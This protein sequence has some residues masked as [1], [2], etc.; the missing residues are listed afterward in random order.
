M[1]QA[2]RSHSTVARLPTS[3]ER[4]VRNPD[5]WWTRP[6]PQNCEALNARHWKP[7]I[8]PQTAAQ[9]AT[10]EPSNAEGDRTPEL[11]IVLALLTGDTEATQRVLR[12]LVGLYKSFPDDPAILAAIKMVG[13]L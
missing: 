8:E 4:P 2:A 9:R 11:A 1:T 3:R 12:G 10:P 6:L 5:G 7:Q 13:D